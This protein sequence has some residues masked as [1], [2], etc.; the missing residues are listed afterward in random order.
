M[1]VTAGT[2][3]GDQ[4]VL[5][6]SQT[7]SVTVGQTASLHVQLRHRGDDHDHRLGG[8]RPRRPATNIPIG[9]ANTGLQPYG[10]YSYAAGHDDADAAVPV[11]GGL[12]GVRRATAPTTTR[13]AWTRP[14]NLFYPTRAPSPVTVTPGGTTAHDGA[15]LR[16]ADHGHERAAT[17]VVGATLTATETTGYA[18]R[19]TPRCARAAARSGTA[20]TLGL[21][22]TGAGGVSLTAVPLGHWTIKATVGHQA[23]HGQDLAP[24][25]RRLQ[26]DTAD[27]ARRRGSAL[28][29]V[30]VTVS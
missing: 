22:T 9:I 24:D 7:T 19:R 4:E 17:P 13:S 23:R 25:H 10:Q 27:A 28:P 6:P 5:V 12:H 8:H 26:R 21:V 29:T 16:P 15:A 30:T 2:G 1:T 20:P 3:V 14:R 11:P 18:A